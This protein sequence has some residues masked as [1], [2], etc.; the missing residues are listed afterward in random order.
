MATNV[1]IAVPDRVITSPLREMIEARR[2][3]DETGE[4]M[5]RRV[6]WPVLRNQSAMTGDGVTATIALP[7]AFA[8]LNAG[9]AVI[10]A[11]APVRPLSP[12]EWPGLP[13]AVGQPRYFLLTGNTVRLWPV[14]GA[15]VQVTVDWQSGEWVA[16]GAFVADTDEPVID[17]A[18]LTRGLIVRWRRQKGM[19]YADEEAEYEAML[20]D[21][22]RRAWR[23]R[24]P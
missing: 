7:A 18:T 23:A 3:A 4:E 11:G 5:A 12:Q 24:L 9:L 15:G 22:Q 19:P 16:T 21:A 2:F 6:D 10:A 20:A 17:A 8:R 14:P 13:A 1:G